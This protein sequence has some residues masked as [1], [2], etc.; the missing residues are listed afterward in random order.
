MTQDPHIPSDAGLQELLSSLQSDRLVFFPIRHHSPACAWHLSRLIRDT[1]PAAILI[2][3]PSDFMEK[4]PLLLHPDAK[5]PFAIYCTYAGPGIGV[6]RQ[7]KDDP[8]V[9]PRLAAYYPFC[10]Y[11]PEL[12][13][14]RVGQEVGAELRFIDLTFAEQVQVRD[15]QTRAEPGAKMRSLLEEV[16]LKRSAYVQRLAARTGCRDHDELWDHLFEVR[17][18]DMPTPEFMRNVAAY[19]YMARLDFSDEVL[20]ADGT[21]ARESAMAQGIRQARSE[22]GGDGPVVVVTGGLH[23]VALPRLVSKGRLRRGRHRGKRGDEQTLLTRFSYDQLD[24]LNGYA[25][26][27][28]SPGYYHSLWQRY[29]D[30][31]PFLAT[32]TELLV[33]LGRTIRQRDM[34]VSLSAADEIT[35]LE[36]AKGLAALRG[37]AGPTREDL[38]DAVRS[39]YVKGSLE[40]EGFEILRC[41]HTV[42]SGTA[43][44][45]LPAEAGVPPIVE[46]FR[47]R[48][49]ELRLDLNDTAPRRSSLEIYRRPNHRRTSRLFHALE[50]L[51][52]PFANLISG[53]D[54]VTGRGLDLVQEIW[55]YCWSPLTESTL[56]EKALYGS[57]VRDATLNLLLEQIQ[58]LESEGKA[59]SAAEAVAALVRACRMGLH[60]DVPHVLDAISSAVT[61]DPS[62]VSLVQGL[63]QLVLVWH[64]R[65]P[66]EAQNL[67]QIPA[68]AK[69]AY[70]H[71]TYLIQDLENCPEELVS[72]TLDGFRVLRELLAADEDGLLDRE[73]FL[74][75]TRLLLGKPAQHSAITGGAAGVLYAEGDLDDDQLSRLLAGFLEGATADVARKTGFLRGLMKTCRAAAWRSPDL[76]GRLDQLV[77]EW[78]HDDFV[79]SLPELRLAFADLTSSETDTVAGRVAGLHGESDL[80]DLVHYDLSEAE[81]AEGIRL[82]EQVTA[83]LKRDGLAAWA[84]EPEHE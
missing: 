31:D 55:E 27:M 15:L 12:V 60:P 78:A 32:A 34:P 49:E 68:C 30:A 29:H 5:A 84:A 14:L 22:V 21:L 61:D 83:I 64:S 52:V 75:R 76:L 28:P 67:T 4:T 39:C 54:F 33:E 73:L 6:D 42:L 18:A 59:R 51:G 56:I 80:G 7:A 25:S 38:L 66:L 44:G 17:A 48:A 43:I 41:V 10:D 62:F 35:A 37:H 20:E 2:E 72:A 46:D 79:R 19:C 1:R 13:A 23:T 57:T 77:R 16:H 11:S 58:A 63:N 3:G 26:G 50:Y 81:L 24:A 65:E 8:A 82:N 69:A 40:A 53:P 74:T 70:N 45:Q 9:P 71:A 47:Q 36:H